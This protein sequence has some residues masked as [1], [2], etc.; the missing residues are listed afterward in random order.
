MSRRFTIRWLPQHEAKAFVKQHHSHHKPMRGAILCLGAYEGDRLCAVA[1]IGRPSARMLDLRREVAEITRHCTDR[2]EH[3]ASKLYA[4]C[5]RVAQVLGFDRIATYTLADESGVS[6]IA[7][8]FR[9]VRKT[10][11]GSWNRRLRKR[12]DKHSTAPKMFW[13]SAA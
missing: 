8:G 3:V 4:Q 7:A 11:G 9:P 10:R 13:E 5:R 2:T 1:A 6:L 12:T